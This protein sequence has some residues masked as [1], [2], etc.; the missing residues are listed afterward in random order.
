MAPVR[1]LHCHS[2]FSLGGKEARA[3]RLMNAFGDAAE[4][5][6]LSAMPDRLGARD[7]I[8]PDIRVSFPTGA[9]PLTGP[10][11]PRR[12][13]RLAS[14]LRG[15]DLVLSYNWG[16]FDA[17]MARRLFAGLVR[18]PPLIHHEDGFNED[19]AVRLDPRRNRYRRFGLPAA[20][21]LVV[22][23]KRLE[24]V[25]RSHWSR[26]ALRIPNG[27]PVARFARPP[28]AGAIPGFERRPGEIVIGTVAGLRAVKNL[29]RLVRAVAAMRSK[30]VRLVIVGEGPESDR[31][32][33][34]AG[35]HGLGARLVMPGFLT[36]PARWIAHFDIFA[37]SSDSEQF[38]ISLVE[39]MAAGLPV[40]ATAVGDVIEMVSADNRPLIVEPADEA[41]FTAALDSL[42]EQTALRH[43]IGA[44]NRATA[45]TEYDE[46][47]MIAAYARLYGEAIGRPDAFA[48]C[49]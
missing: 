3:V 36:D 41:G 38:P 24:T 37:L 46:A 28:E 17:V 19:E 49:A 23:S 42:A 16:A 12:L 15:F 13:W 34:E 33:A 39:A 8:S 40:V 35:A 4:H 25:A 7:A 31:I 27:V 5:S 26:A 11:T 44:A 10:P 9:P 22:P 1:I 45:R 6:I 2:T 18:L 14:Y 47:K 48:P 30:D 29:P 21:A 32:A 20:R 43:A